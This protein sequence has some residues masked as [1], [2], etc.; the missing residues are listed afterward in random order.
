MKAQETYQKAIKL[1][2]DPILPVR[3]HGLLLLRQLVNPKLA[4]LQGTSYID[5]ALIPSII[6]IFL[7]A[8]Q[9]DDSYMFLNAVQGFSAMVD[10]FGKDVL[11]TLITEYSRSLDGLSGSNL[12]QAD[13][14]KRTR[15]GEAL[16]QVIRRYGSALGI[17]GSVL[18]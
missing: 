1:L 18:A 4:N 13:V 14:D 9:D 17:Y 10:T 15:V 2:Q 7:Q 11:K 6:A 8:I 3:A 12:T 5:P 16:G